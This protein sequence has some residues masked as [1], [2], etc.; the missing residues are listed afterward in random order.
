MD[1]NWTWRWKV[2]VRV[3]MK[4]K[5]KMGGESNGEWR[6]ENVGELGKGKGCQADFMPRVGYC[7]SDAF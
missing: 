4:M 7:R 3:K 2:K 6:M 5:E 1:H